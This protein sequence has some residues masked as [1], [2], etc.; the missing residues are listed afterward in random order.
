MDLPHEPVPGGIGIQTEAWYGYPDPDKARPICLGDSQLRMPDRPRKDRLCP[1][2]TSLG[3][4]TD[5]H[6]DSISSFHQV[7]VDHHHSVGA[8]LESVRGG[9]HFCGLLLIAWEEKCFLCQ[10]P[11]GAW[12][13]RI[14][15]YAV[16]L[17]GGIKLNFRR[18]RP[19]KNSTG[20]KT[21]GIEITILCGNMMPSMGGRLLC[22]PK[23]SECFEF[24][25]YCWLLK[26]N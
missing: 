1:T 10:Q 25:R 4:L 2:C 18:L 8:L 20:I 23:E 5:T 12:I 14:K 22:T 15:D 7:V 19:K 17:D 11:S 24:E 6:W 13:G 9:C 21:H 26:L 3:N 16:S